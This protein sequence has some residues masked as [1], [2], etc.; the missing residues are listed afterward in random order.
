MCSTHNKCQTSTETQVQDFPDKDQ[1]LK[2]L[3]NKLQTDEESIQKI[4]SIGEEA[5]EVWV[6]QASV[7][8]HLFEELL[9][10]TSTKVKEIESQLFKHEVDARLFEPVNYRVIRKEA[11]AWG[12]F[13]KKPVGPT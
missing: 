3:Q 10:Q 5:I 6:I 13:I 2:N 9:S 1:H 7:H 8:K 4:E 12:V 11:N